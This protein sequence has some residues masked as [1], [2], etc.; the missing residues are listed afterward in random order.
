MDKTLPTGTSSGVHFI[1]DM[2]GSSP[3]THP[4]PR[5]ET[6]MPEGDPWDN[7]RPDINSPVRFRMVVPGDT[8]PIPGYF[9]YSKRD[10]FA[11]RIIFGDNAENVSW[12]VGRVILT[13]GIERQTGEGD[14]RVW[15]SGTNL[16]MSL[17][18]SNGTC[19]LHVNL[20]TVAIF[21]KATQ[22]LVPPGE[23]V[24]DWDYEMERIFT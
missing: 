6:R 5:K 8:V 11:I 12:I 2:V 13:A 16:V 19:L 1:H 4:Q 21:L 15:P 17:S 9:Q 10:P 24:I 23:E 14:V 18:S 7:I 22:S 20:A 3:A